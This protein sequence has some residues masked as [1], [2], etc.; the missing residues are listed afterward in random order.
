[1]SRNASFIALVIVLTAGACARP[2]GEPQPTGELQHIAEP[3][4]RAS[5]PAQHPARIDRSPSGTTQEAPAA[6][7][8]PPRAAPSLP[9][10]PPR[11][12][13]FPRVHASQLAR[14]SAEEALVLFGK[15]VRASRDDGTTA[16]TYEAAGCRLHLE[17]RFSFAVNAL[18]ASGYELAPETIP[19]SICLHALAKPAPRI[20]ARPSN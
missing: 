6:E 13:R 2:G 3:P 12:P 5:L 7:P 15:P 17:F 9:P 18:R 8:A 19:A 16:W 1:M 14:L 4:A 10:K 20:A 11:R